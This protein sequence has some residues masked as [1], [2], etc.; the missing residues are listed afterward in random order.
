MVLDVGDV[1]VVARLLELLERCTEIEPANGICV[2]L[3]GVQTEQ[4]RGSQA[5][6]PCHACLDFRICNEPQFDMRE[7]EC[8]RR[9]VVDQAPDYIHSSSRKRGGAQHSLRD[10]LA[11]PRSGGHAYIRVYQLLITQ[12]L[13]D[14][15]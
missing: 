2:V 8:L 10:V 1:V 4:A 3:R 6:V 9:S 11:V 15:S 5:V 12:S 7:L 14:V 13:T